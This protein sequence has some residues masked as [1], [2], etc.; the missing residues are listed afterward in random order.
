M[1]PAH[2][3][4]TIA[5]HSFSTL[6]IA[7]VPLSAAHRARLTPFFSTIYHYETYSDISKPEELAEADVL[8]GF[9]PKTF[10]S[11]RQAPRLQ[12]IQLASAGS[13]YVV[14]GP[15]GKDEEAGKLGLA[16]AAGVH[17]GPIPQVRA[18]PIQTRNETEIPC[19]V[20]H[21]HTTG[22]LQQAAGAS[23]DLTGTSGAS[24]FPPIR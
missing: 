19:S 14:D 20:L 7:G 18:T 3:T 10:T 11:L 2:S 9:P 12:F 15:L 24:F 17:T 13:E 8:Y 5:K 23:V 1:G 16:T 4:S 21:L 6:F 22:P